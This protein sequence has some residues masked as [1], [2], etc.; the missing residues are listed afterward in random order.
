MDN[1]D[2]VWVSE[3]VLKQQPMGREG[4]VG[5][6]KL[7]DWI[8]CIWDISYQIWERWLDRLKNESLALGTIIAS[9]ESKQGNNDSGHGSYLFKISA[10][11]FSPSCKDSGNHIH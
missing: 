1:V 4:S 10:N 8:G 11:Y 7:T 6:W 5:G 9:F 2:F 3:L